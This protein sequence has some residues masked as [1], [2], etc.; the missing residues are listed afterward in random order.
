VEET[1]VTFLG[2]KVEIKLK[3]AESGSWAKLDF[4]RKVIEMRLCR[5]QK[6][7]LMFI[8]VEVAANKKPKEEDI[9][10]DVTVQVEALDLDDLEVPVRRAVLSNEASNGRTGQSVI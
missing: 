6:L 5:L 8:K 4:P 10:D 7:Q 2:T 3:K 9:D 1:T